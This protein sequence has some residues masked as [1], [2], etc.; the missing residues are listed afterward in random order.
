MTENKSD[1][2]KKKKKKKKAIKFQLWYT[3]MVQI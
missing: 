3:E 2:L 1:K